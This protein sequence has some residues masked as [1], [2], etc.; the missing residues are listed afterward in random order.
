[1]LKA[2]KKYRLAEGELLAVPPVSHEPVCI[3]VMRPPGQP[4]L[5]ITALNFSQKTLKEE[6]DLNAE[7]VGKQHLNGPMVEIITDQHLGNVPENGC[8]TIELSPLSAK[9]IRIGKPR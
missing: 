1:M 3:L 8:I 6:F 5:V 2:R 9:T 4:T 7:G